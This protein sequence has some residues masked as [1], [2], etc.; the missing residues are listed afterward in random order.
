MAEVLEHLYFWLKANPLRGG[1]PS[2]FQPE[3]RLLLPHTQHPLRSLELPLT[4]VLFL[5]HFA[6]SELSRLSRC[7]PTPNLRG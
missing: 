3:E 4:D 7:L 1:L 2:G 5:A 6:P